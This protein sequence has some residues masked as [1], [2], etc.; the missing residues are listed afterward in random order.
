MLSAILVSV[1]DD[2]VMSTFCDNYICCVWDWEQTI[3]KYIS[4]HFT[5]FRF[6]WTCCTAH[7]DM[8]TARVCRTGMMSMEV[9][10]YH[11]TSFW[12]LGVPV[13]LWGSK[14]L[15]QGSSWSPSPCP[16]GFPSITQAGALHSQAGTLN[17][18]GT[19]VLCNSP[20]YWKTPQGHGQLPSTH[21]PRTWVRSILEAASGV[22]KW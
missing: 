20:L 22:S 11:S 2:L 7:T 10:L 4:K 21:E 3:F 12:S 17:H 9:F 1:K 19:Q 15:S 5:A 14:A 6:L 8:Y 18:A 16:V 13:C